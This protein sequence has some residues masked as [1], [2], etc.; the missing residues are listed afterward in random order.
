MILYLDSMF[1]IFHC[2]YKTVFFWNIR[3]IKLQSFESFNTRESEGE[4]V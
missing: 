2:K 3:N 4:V 1:W